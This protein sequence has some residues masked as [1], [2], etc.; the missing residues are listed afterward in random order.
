MENYGSVKYALMFFL[1]AMFVSLIFSKNKWV[2]LGELYK[3]VGGALVFVAVG[4]LSAADKKSVLSWILSA[5][6]LV[7]L[8]AIYQYYFG[9]QHLLKNVAG[10]GPAESFALDYITRRRP[11]LPFVTPNILAGYLAMTLPLALVSKNKFWIGLFISAALLLTKSLGAILSVFA[12]LAI[13]FYLRGNLKK[14]GFAFLTGI[15]I[16]AVLVC[17]ARSAMAKQHTHPLFSLMMR[18]NYWGDALRI[19]A[20]YPLTG[21]GLGNF[22]LIYSRY[23]HNSYLQIWAE[24]GVFGLASF[25]WLATA[26]VKTGLDNFMRS[27]NKKV[28]AGL[29]AAQCIF[30]FHNLF[31]FTFFLPEVSLIWWV[32]NGIIFPGD[33]TPA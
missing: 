30:L 17:I 11:F 4:S 9:F 29:I 31:D 15:L 28:V 6:F 5:A 7:S 33:K 25:L 1:L 13:Y 8:L 26:L 2:S 14:T 24:T 10:A 20:A 16:T 19:I 18:L 27:G 32:I 22:N 21:V 12:G 23:A 3:Y